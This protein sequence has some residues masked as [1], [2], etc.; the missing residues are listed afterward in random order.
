MWPGR[1]PLGQTGRDQA[2]AAYSVY[3][4]RTLLVL[5][6]PSGGSS[7]FLAD[8]QQQQTHS[9]T[10]Q[11]QGQQQ[12]PLQPRAN[13]QTQQ[14]Q[15]QQLLAEG[16]CVLRRR[17]PTEPVDVAQAFDVFEFVL[18]DRTAADGDSS[19]VNDATSGM[20]Q[21]RREHARL[22]PS[23]NVAPANIA[24]AAENQAYAALLT[25]WISAGGCKLRYSGGMVPDVHHVLAKVRH[26]QCARCHGDNSVMPL[27]IKMLLPLQLCC[28]PTSPATGS[29]G[30]SWRE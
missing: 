1:S 20:W 27:S 5:A 26:A 7:S 17:Q 30:F 3:G 19:S 4:P 22:G 11:Q 25:R 13:Q 12:Q 9:S 28:L 10:E 16:E 23:A 21:L 2:A 15:Q 24:A 18:L 29:L 14:T 6:L 8:S